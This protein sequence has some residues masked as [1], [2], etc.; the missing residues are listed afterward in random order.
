MFL[1]YVENLS[2][3][4]KEMYRIL[5]LSGKFIIID[6]DEYNFEFLKIE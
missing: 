4:I 5:K 2:I 1:Y 3:V 6:L